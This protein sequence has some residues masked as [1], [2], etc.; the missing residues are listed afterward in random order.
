MASFRGSM[1]VHEVEHDFIEITS[2][3]E[4]FDIVEAA[5]LSSLVYN[6]FPEG[7]IHIL[8]TNVVATSYKGHLAANYKGHF[9]LA[10]DNGILPLIFGETFS[11]YYL[12]PTPNYE[13]KI[14]NVYLPFLKKLA[15]N[16]GSL[17]PIAEPT[18]DIVLK[19][20]IQ[21]VFDDKELHGTVLF[22]DHF[23]NA[24]TNIHEED[25]KRFCSDKDYRI[26]LARHSQ[27]NAIS[28]NFADVRDGDPLCYFSDNGYLVASIKKS[29]AYQLLNLRKYKP[30]II[31]LT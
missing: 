18:S 7:S 28:T 30:V 13:Q 11:E 14:Q 31:E 25:F 20:R 27:V 17:N 4:P 3:I 26:R 15:A 29:S 19:T 23:G 2:G 21:P 22:I 10:P 8:A 24:Y 6:D 16:N 5:Y 12:I 1:K 9:F